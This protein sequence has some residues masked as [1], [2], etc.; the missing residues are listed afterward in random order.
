MCLMQGNHA[1]VVAGSSYYNIIYL[2]AHYNTLN[3]E[4]KKAHLASL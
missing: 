4:I 3:V 2:F 1:C